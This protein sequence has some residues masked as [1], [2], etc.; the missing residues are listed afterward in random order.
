MR[1]VLLLLLATALVLPLTCTAGF[2]QEDMP[3]PAADQP[4][5][6]QS[7]IAIIAPEDGTSATVGEKL[8]IMLVVQ[9]DLKPTTIAVM[10][11]SKGIGMLQAPPYQLDWDTTG[12]AAGEHVLRA[13]AY[14][15]SGER[16]GAR[17]VVVNLTEA[18]PAAVMPVVLSVPPATLK[19]GTAVLLKTVETMTSGKVPEGGTVRLKVARDVTGPGGVVVIEYGAMAEGRVTRSR[20]RGWFGKAGQL[21]F[22][23]DSVEAVDGTQVPLRASQQS[24]G[25]SN[26][27]VVVASFLVLTVL[28]IFVHGQD[29]TIPAD[30]EIT[31]YVDHLTDIGAPLPARPGGELRGAPAEQAAIAR[32]V[33]GQVVPVGTDIDVEV[34]ASPA[35]KVAVIKLIADGKEVRSEKGA[36]RPMKCST[37]G[38]AA[39][40]HTFEA[41]VTFLSGLVMRT[42]PVTVSLV[43]RQ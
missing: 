13:F 33:T 7:P 24:A 32:P 39:G 40:S 22:T 35:D 28:A 8:T 36:P 4:A 43:A 37:R 21:E 16:I 26:R 9:G 34:Q 15:D 30:T 41:E 12:A 18:A 3:P 27:G 20:G 2:P 10:V 25:K 17:P 42:M 38:F 6:D 23:I 19:E 11:D 1:T 29:I 31:A 14:T 5:S